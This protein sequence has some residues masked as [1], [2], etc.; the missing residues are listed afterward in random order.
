MSSTLSVTQSK[1]KSHI[2]TQTNP[3]WSK[4][5]LAVIKRLARKRE[6][7]TSADVLNDLD[8]SDVATADLRAIG[9]ECGDYDF[10]GI[11]AFRRFTPPSEGR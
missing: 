10:G 5:A 6:A 3:K 1:P 8:K 11:K 9:W 7:L 4:S 2:N